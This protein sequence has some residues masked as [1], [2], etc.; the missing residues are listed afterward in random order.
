MIT[1][2]HAHSRTLAYTQTESDMDLV[3]SISAG[4]SVALCK[5]VFSLLNYGLIEICYI[6][7]TVIHSKLSY[8]R[9]K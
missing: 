6:Y 9:A 2:K 3:G 1:V 7:Q 8:L 4:A 5:N